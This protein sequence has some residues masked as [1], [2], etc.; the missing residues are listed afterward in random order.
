MVTVAL[1]IFINQKISFSFIHFVQIHTRNTLTKKLL[2]KRPKQKWI[3]SKFSKDMTKLK[4]TSKIHKNNNNNNST[5]TKSPNPS[6]PQFQSSSSSSSLP[7]LYL[8]PFSTTTPTQPSHK[9]L[10]THSTQ[11]SQSDPFAT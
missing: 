8:S 11:P 4:T 2:K 5:D 9:P 10:S 6:L 3:L 7:S 1:T